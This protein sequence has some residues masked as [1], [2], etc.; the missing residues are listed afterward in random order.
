MSAWAVQAVSGR[1]LSAMLD[2]VNAITGPNGPQSQLQVRS[3]HP[4]LHQ[5]LSQARMRWLGGLALRRLELGP[6]STRA[7]TPPSVP[8]LHFSL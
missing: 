8:Q 7:A 3:H 4:V 6:S 5:L 2:A 1:R